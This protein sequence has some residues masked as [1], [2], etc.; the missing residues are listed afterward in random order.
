MAK[1]DK[2]IEGIKK[3]QDSDIFIEDSEVEEI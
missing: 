3:L 1:R 2:A